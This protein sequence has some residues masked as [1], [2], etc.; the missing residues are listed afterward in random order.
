MKP[1]AVIDCETTGLNIASDAIVSLAIICG[2]GIGH[3]YVFKPWKEIPEEVEELTGLTNEFVSTKAPFKQDAAL[4]HSILKGCD[5]A[6]FNVRGFDIPII[7]EELYRSGI[8]WDL[9]ETL[10]ID[11][12][13]IFKLREA[14]TLSAAMQF[15]CNASHDG[16][17]NAMDDCKATQKVL[18]AQL[19]RYPDLGKLDRAA[20]S[21]ASE[22]EG[23]QRLS[24]DGKIMVGPDGDAIYAFGKHK[25]KKVK[26]HPEYGEWMLTADFPAH[27]K[28]VLR[29]LMGQSG[30]R[31][32]GELPF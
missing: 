30:T 9:S 32:A 2:T 18:E 17:H 10:V 12:G 4:I 20:L 13:V 27:T 24:L 26:D 14:R 29:R 25:D 21:K 1:L 19:Q 28:G 6:G 22:Y 8:E 23:P 31:K 11:A 3:Y 16:A 15:Y 7:Y 5:L